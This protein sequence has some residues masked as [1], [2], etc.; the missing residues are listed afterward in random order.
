MPLSTLTLTLAI[1]QASL[2]AMMAS[3]ALERIERLHA[4]LLGPHGND[5]LL[6]AQG[7]TGDTALE[8]ARKIARECLSDEEFANVSS[9]LAADATAHGPW[10]LRSDNNVGAENASLL[11]IEPIIDDNWSEDPEDWSLLA[12]LLTARGPG[13]AQQFT[14]SPAV[15]RAQQIAIEKI[16][17]QFNVDA[18]DVVQFLK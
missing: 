5:G 2:A 17:T 11:D 7:V 16:A 4:C 14:G 8:V 13:L 12:L 9:Y 1:N 10:V 3:D 15:Y 6:A 18:K